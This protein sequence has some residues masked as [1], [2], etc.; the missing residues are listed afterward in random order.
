MRVWCPA[1]LKDGS[2]FYRILQPAERDPE[3][4]VW[5]HIEGVPD[6]SQGKGTLLVQRCHMEQHVQALLMAKEAGWKIVY[7]ID[8]DLFHVPFWNP[9]S[10]VYG[11]EEVQQRLR[12]CMG[13]SD[14][15]TVSTSRLKEIV[16]I[17]LSRN[18]HKHLPP[19]AVLPNRIDLSRWRKKTKK[20]TDGKIVIAWA[21][22]PT[23]KLD[24]DVVVH[25]LKTLLIDRPQVMLVFVGYRPQALGEERVMYFPW[26]SVSRYQNVLLSVKPDIAILPLV[27]EPFNDSKSNIKFLEFAAM[28]ASCVAS[29][30]GPYAETIRDNH[31]G[32]L[33]RDNVEE[34]W[35]EGLKL[36]VDDAEYRK[37][38][39]QNAL[40]QVRAGWSMEQDWEQR[41][42]VYEQYGVM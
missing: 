28:R 15:L 17:Q 29:D 30:V 41:A 3:G 34:D 42:Q 35:I 31:T 12:I 18:G 6:F 20:R 11:A 5:T 4:K 2:A 36:L 24:L 26:V 10:A 14:L 27:Q 1:T 38:L 25:A 7:D 19:I 39:A 33:V 9:S 22:S 8:D 21:G 23:H 40:E 13:L 16:R 32:L 37:T